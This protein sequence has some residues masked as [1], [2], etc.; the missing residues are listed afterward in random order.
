M[1]KFN[2][3]NGFTY[4]TSDNAFIIY[5]GGPKEWYSAPVDAELAAKFGYVSVAAVDGNKVFHTSLRQ[6]QE[7]VRTFDYAGRA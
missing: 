2:R 4:K 7:W 3:V 1:I 5:N 6:A